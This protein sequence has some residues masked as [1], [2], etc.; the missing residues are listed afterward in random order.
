VISLNKTSTLNS[1]SSIL[2]IIPD[3]INVTLLIL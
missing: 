3:V 2:I 1:E